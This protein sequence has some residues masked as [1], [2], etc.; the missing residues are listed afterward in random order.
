LLLSPQTNTQE[1]IMSTVRFFAAV[2]AVIA[3]MTA[4]ALAPSVA[5]PVKTGLEACDNNPNS[6][7]YSK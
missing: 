7:S 5:M 4:M 1:T 3:S 2:A 6:C